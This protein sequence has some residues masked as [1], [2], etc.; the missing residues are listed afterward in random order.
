MTLLR[1]MTGTRPA[2]PGESQRRHSQVTPEIGGGLQIEAYSAPMVCSRGL[3]VDHAAPRN[4][5]M[6]P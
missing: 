1:M 6:S 2:G 4:S 5:R 3:K